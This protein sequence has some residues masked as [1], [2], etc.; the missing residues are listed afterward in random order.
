MN[1]FHARARIPALAIFTCLLLFASEPA[2]A[3]TYRLECAGVSAAS[4]GWSSTTHTL[5]GFAG[6]PQPIRISSNANHILI[7]GFLACITNLARCTGEAVARV[8][9][10]A[11]P[12]QGSQI[13]VPLFINMAGVPAPDEKLGSFS[14]S[15]SWNPALL[16]YVSHTALQSGFTGAVNSDNASLGLLEFNGANPAGVAGNVPILGI[17]F[18]VVGAAGANGTLDLNYTDILA[19]GTFGN[20]LPCLTVNDSPFTI[21]PAPACLVCGDVNDD[22]V[23]GSSDAL[24]ILSYD[25]GITIPQNLLDKINAGCGDVNTD[26]ATNSSDALIILTYDAG[27][28]VPFAVGNPG[29]CSTVSNPS[30]PFRPTVREAQLSTSGSKN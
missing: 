26:G 17:T 21:A 2:T 30:L 16:N 10:P 18:E 1:R 12:V 24:I 11:A 19:A 14:G 8:E 15:L 27:L 3:Q 20:L 28:P 4:G 9:G 5:R 23:A 6:Q 13:N 22:G 25:V 29:G 7:P